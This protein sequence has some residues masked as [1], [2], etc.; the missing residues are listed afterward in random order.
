MVGAFAPNKRVDIAVEAFTRMKLP[1]LIV[2]SGQEESRLKKMAG[3]T[4]DFLGPVSNAVI[5]DLYSKCRAF[6]FPGMDDFGITPVEAMSA[7]VPVIAYGAGGV[8]DTVT[9]KTGILFSPQTSEA[10]IEAVQKLESGVVTFDEKD[11]RSRAAEFSR[12]RFREGYFAAVQDAWVSAGRD[13]QK[14]LQAVDQR[15]LLGDV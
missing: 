6:V 15:V 8:L 13:P 9:S 3:P 14:L 10:L 11:C 2:G 7:G 5:A 4:I 12:E 1:L